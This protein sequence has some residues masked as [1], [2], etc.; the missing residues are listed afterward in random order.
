[1]GIGNPFPSLKISLQATD[2][3]AGLN[4]VQ[5]FSGVFSSNKG[6]TIEICNAVGHLDGKVQRIIGAYHSDS[7][8]AQPVQLAKSKCL[9]V[10]FLLVVSID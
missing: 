4:P 1:M 3:C 5:R 2:Y 9:I 6:E 7:R 10:D 8:T